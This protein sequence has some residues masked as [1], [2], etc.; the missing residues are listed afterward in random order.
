MLIYTYN[1]YTTTNNPYYKAYLIKVIEVIV[2]DTI[3][4]AYISY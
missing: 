4:C 3:L 1:N 2:L